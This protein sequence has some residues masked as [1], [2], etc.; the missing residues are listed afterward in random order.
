[1]SMRRCAAGP[2]RAYGAR[3]RARIFCQRLEAELVGIDVA[4]LT[5]EDIAPER[6]GKP[7]QIVFAGE[8]L[9]RDAPLT[10]QGRP[11]RTPGG[12]RPGGLPTQPRLC[13]SK[14]RRRGAACARRS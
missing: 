11:R 13:G 7:A 14:L 12:V 4:Y 5:A 10:A 9:P 2:S 6:L 3:A 8:S 1:M